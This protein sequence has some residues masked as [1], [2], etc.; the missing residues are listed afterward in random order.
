MSVIFKIF[1]QYEYIFIF[2]EI[3]LKLSNQNILYRKTPDK[4]DMAD[5]TETMVPLPVHLT[6]KV[7]S[8]LV[9]IV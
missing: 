4:T 3:R 5:S 7:S 8:N 2:V 1:R 9:W 6:Q